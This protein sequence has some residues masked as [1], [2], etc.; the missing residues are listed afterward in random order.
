VVYEAH[1]LVVVI[2]KT[3]RRFLSSTRR[4]MCLAT[5]VAMT[6]RRWGIVTPRCLLCPMDAGQEF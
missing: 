3:A 5:P 6:S 4:N 1:E 2:G